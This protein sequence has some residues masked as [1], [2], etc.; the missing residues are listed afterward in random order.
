[1]SWHP[2][3]LD[4]AVLPVSPAIDGSPRQIQNCLETVKGL[5]GC[6]TVG[7]KIDVPTCFALFIFY[8]MQALMACISTRHTVVWSPRLTCSQAPCIHPS[9]SASVSLGPVCV[10]DEALCNILF[11]PVLPVTLVRKLDSERFG[12][13]YMGFIL[14]FPICRMGS[15]SMSRDFP[16]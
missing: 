15:Y 13:A 2:Y 4:P 3:Q 9:T 5:N 12:Y 6:L 8:I 7:K 11:Q 14:S 1:V 16:A 10:P